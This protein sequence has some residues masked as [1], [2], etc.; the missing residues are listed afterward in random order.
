MSKI[1][2]DTVIKCADLLKTLTKD[3]SQTASAQIHR[4]FGYNS[5]SYP[6]EANIHCPNC[7][8]HFTGDATWEAPEG[9]GTDCP[10]CGDEIILNDWEF[11]SVEINEKETNK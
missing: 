2:N 3:D 1:L 11:H 6:N 5:Y 9:Q 8:F 7:D 10:A 4:M